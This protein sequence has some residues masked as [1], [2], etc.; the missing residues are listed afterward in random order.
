MLLIEAE[1]N[2]APY[3]VDGNLYD[4]QVNTLNSH[5]RKAV[6]WQAHPAAHCGA[7]PVTLARITVYAASHV[8]WSLLAWLATRAT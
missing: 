2:E 6:M 7:A 3:D 1:G 4:H 8:R 5:I